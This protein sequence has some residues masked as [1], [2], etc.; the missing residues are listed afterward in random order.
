M[1]NNIVGWFEIPVNDM[2]RAKKFYDTILKTEI[3]VMEL[4]PLVM[5]W[6]PFYPD[7]P[8]SPGAL[9]LHPGNYSPSASKGVLIY[10]SCPDLQD[11]LD[12]VVDAGGKILLPKRQVSEHFGY[13]CLLLDSEGN[14][15]ALHSRS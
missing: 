9:V 12:R 1:E 7:K 14:R 6:F 4:G 10:L 8:G 2:Q 5:G 13:M 11:C 15:I 3:K